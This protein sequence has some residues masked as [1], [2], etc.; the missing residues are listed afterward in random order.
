MKN[1]ILIYKNDNYMNTLN[2]GLFLHF[3]GIPYQILKNTSASQNIRSDANIFIDID[4]TIENVIEIF[5]TKGLINDKDKKDLFDCLKIF[6]ECEYTKAFYMLYFNQKQTD[7]NIFDKYYKMYENTF[8]KL[9]SIPIKKMNNYRKYAALLI[10]YEI[11][12]I[13]KKYNLGQRYVDE[14]SIID[15]CLDATSKTKDI[16]YKLLAVMVYSNLTE[17]IKSAFDLATDIRDK[18]N[19]NSEVYYL[20]GDIMYRLPMLQNTCDY[21]TTCAKLDNTNYRAIY[22]LGCSLYKLELPDTAYKVFKKLYDF[23]KNERQYRNLNNI[24]LEY[25]YATLLLLITLTVNKDINLAYG[26]CK[27]AFL[28]LNTKP[29]IYK[30]ISIE[31]NEANSI[32]KNLYNTLDTKKLKKYGIEISCK[33]GLEDE[34]KIFAKI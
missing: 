15:T 19:Y 9:N 6:K 32:R 24:E 8:D 20:I 5:K 28:V 29:I 30:E 25:L 27:E 34:A 12:V 33:L 10:A 2:I 7:I 23:F 31:D 16:K 1:V 14:I 13:G 26:Y 3:V 4:Q 11:D 22:K 17:D 21:M 18:D